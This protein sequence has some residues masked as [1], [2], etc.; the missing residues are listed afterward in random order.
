MV[1]DTICADCHKAGEQEKTRIGV[2]FCQRWKTHQVQDPARNV[3][4]ICAKSHEERRH[5][6]NLA[7]PAMMSMFATPNQKS[8]ELDEE[9]GCG[10]RFMPVAEVIPGVGMLDH[11]GDGHGN[12]NDGDD[13]HMEEEDVLELK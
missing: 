13:S 5:L 11:G 7:I 4:R 1:R 3:C 10:G 2:T 12:G 6:K 9:L 8:E